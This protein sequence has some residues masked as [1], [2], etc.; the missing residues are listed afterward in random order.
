MNTVKKVKSALELSIQAVLKAVREG[1]KN[2]A[3]LRAF[4]CDSIALSDFDTLLMKCKDD[5][6]RKIVID[7]LSKSIRNARTEKLTIQ[8]D[9]LAPK[10]DDESPLG[11]QLGVKKGRFDFNKVPKPLG[12]SEK[13]QKIEDEKK[14]LQQAV[15]IANIE[16]SAVLAD[17]DIQQKSIAELTKMI[18]FLTSEVVKLESKNRQLNRHN[19][20][21]KSIVRVLKSQVIDTSNLKAAQ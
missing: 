2:K 18:E 14:G 15:K 4:V 21:Y 7:R 20:R 13:Q 9:L 1:E 16:K 12:K 6:E 10:A 11:Y 19:N 3:T 8:L 17:N 5:D